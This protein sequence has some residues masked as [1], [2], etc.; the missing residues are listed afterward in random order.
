MYKR[1]CAAETRIQTTRREQV[2]ERKQITTRK[3]AVAE[4][5]ASSC[6]N[7]DRH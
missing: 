2:M 1:T 6:T 3:N 4:N 5:E 7:K